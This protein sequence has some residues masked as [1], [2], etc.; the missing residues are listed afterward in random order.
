MRHGIP[1]ISLDNVHMVHRC[2]HP[3]EFIR[4][5]TLVP[6]RLVPGTSFRY[7][8]DGNSMLFRLLDERLD[9]ISAGLEKGR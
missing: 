6:S 7:S 2:T 8:Q 5:T 4:E 1:V 3:R 9:R